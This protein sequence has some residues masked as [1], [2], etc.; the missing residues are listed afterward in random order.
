MGKTVGNL[1]RVRINFKRNK[2]MVDQE[3]NQ[4]K[5][6]VIV[7]EK[8]SNKKSIKKSYK[9][10]AATVIGI[11]HIIC[12]FLAFFANVGLF[13]I[14]PSYCFH[15]G[16]FATEIWSSV[17]FFITG[18]L[19]IGSGRN[20]SSCLV[21]GTMV[22]SILSAI[23]AGILIIFSGLG[24]GIT[25]CYYRSAC[26]ELEFNLL[27]GLELVAGI[28]EMVIAITSSVLSCKATCCRDKLDT[29]N[30]FKVMYRADDDGSI[31]P[32]QI[33]NLASQISQTDGG[34]HT[35][36]EVGFDGKPFNYN[37]F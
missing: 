32:E 20:S 7:V 35:Q 24:F 1:C 16:K 29:S 21:I 30:P 26:S 9:S 6:I 11:I 18:G 12:G 36:T 34:I 5:P 19:S 37:K 13:F 17:F 23:S 8:T 33:M 14:Q 15:F 28:V 10:K 31:D 22:M 3:Q 4:T 25:E 27:H 2:K